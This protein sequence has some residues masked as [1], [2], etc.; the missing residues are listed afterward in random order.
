MSIDTS[1]RFALLYKEDQQQQQQQKKL[2]KKNSQSSPNQPTPLQSRQK[3]QEQQKKRNLEQNTIKRQTLPK[4][5]YKK[6]EEGFQTIQYGKKK[7]QQGEGEEEKK[8]SKEEFLREKQKG[9]SPH[10]VYQKNTN[11]GDGGDENYEEREGGFRTRG[12]NKPRGRGGKNRGGQRG[13]N[14]NYNNY[15]NYDNYNNNNNNDNND[16]DDNEDEDEDED[17]QSKMLG[18]SVLG[19]GNWKWHVK[20]ST[21]RF[22]DKPINAQ[23]E[24]AYKK[25]FERGRDMKN[26][27]CDI[28]IGPEL[29][30]I[31][32]STERQHAKKDIRK[33]RRIVRI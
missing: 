23:I 29:Y 28:K 31:D 13:G 21:F 30:L 14:S 19:N 5:N 2:Q 10:L 22:Y 4:E 27:V 1:N 18:T 16:N 12:G 8:L 24:G 25:W 6:S 7:Q 33:S 17:D 26:A 3:K 11:E 32:F 15:N 20:G 9:G